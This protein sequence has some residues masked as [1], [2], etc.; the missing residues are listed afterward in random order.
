MAP[1]DSANPTAAALAKVNGHSASVPYSPR[2]IITLTKHPPQVDTEAAPQV[3]RAGAP[4]IEVTPEM[5]SAAKV[6]LAAHCWDEGFSMVIGV[7]QAVE[8]AI[9]AAISARP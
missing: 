2:G 8:A 6:A 1:I 4:D 7:D 9:R 5:V 3:C